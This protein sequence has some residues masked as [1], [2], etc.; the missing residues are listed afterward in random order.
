MSRLTTDHAPRP[1]W[2]IG[3]WKMN[4]GL[5][6]AQQLAE[7]LANMTTSTPCEYCQLAVAPMHIHLTTVQA[8]LAAVSAPVRLVA[9]DAAITRGTGAYTGDV[10]VDL[11]KDIGVSK[12]IVGHSERR[13]IH[14]ETE[15]LIGQKLAAVIDADL[16]AIWCI[17]ETLAEREAGQAAAIVEAQIMAHRDWL[18]TI[19][20]AR[21]LIAYEPVWA[22]GTGRAA[23]PDDAQDMHAIIRALLTSI[24]PALNQISLL[25]GGSVKADN[26]RSFAQCP[27]I[28]GALVGGASLDA[29]SFL[30]IAQA[31]HAA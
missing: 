5:T 29:N 7:Q 10:S 16:D 4:P 28:D 13:T 22:I 8:R 15:V 1:V 11:L 18:F 27:D 3:N 17:G 6:A 26:A 24:R 30:Q 19:N 14:G 23:S 2:V 12:V 31:F 25:Y 9:Q 20:P 21:L